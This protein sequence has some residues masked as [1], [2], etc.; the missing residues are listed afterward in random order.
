M[1]LPGCLFL[2]LL[3]A[4]LFSGCLSSPNKIENEPVLSP[5]LLDENLSI[6]DLETQPLLI[7]D[8]NGK[9]PVVHPCT[10]L[11]R[12]V[13]RDNCFLMEA[14]IKGDATMCDAIEDTS[15][16]Y[17]CMYGVARETDNLALC[18]SIAVEGPREI[19]QMNLAVMYDNDYNGLEAIAP[20]AR[21]VCDS[22]PGV[23]KTNCYKR[24]ELAQA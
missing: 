17:A 1:R 15:Q 4:L 19:C 21:A 23:W 8:D 14:A 12:T 9:L 18:R 10:S 5:V 16:Y 20:K 13:D 6:E 3:S 22:L 2:L 11:Q 24:I 7:S